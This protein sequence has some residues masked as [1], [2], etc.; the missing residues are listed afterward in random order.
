VLVGF[1]VLD[2]HP[3]LFSAKIRTGHRRSNDGPPSTV[4]AD[5]NGKMIKPDTMPS[6]ASRCWNS[7]N[8]KPKLFQVKATETGSGIMMNAARNVCRLRTSAARLPSAGSWTRYCTGSR[9]YVRCRRFDATMRRAVDDAV[10][11]TVAAGGGC[12][13]AKMSKISYA[14]YIHRLNGSRSAIRATPKDLDDFPSFKSISWRS[15]GNTPASSPLCRVALP[16]RQG[17]RR[18]T[19]H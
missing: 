14:T 4:S 10:A 3:A 5:K 6:C 7:S 17:R 1:A 15:W 11:K 12:G 16:C 9:R 2:P 19:R 13:A 18:Y 8:C